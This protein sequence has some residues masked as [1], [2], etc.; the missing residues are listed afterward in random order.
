MIRRQFCLWCVRAGLAGGVAAIPAS[1]T[2]QQS[3]A[4]ARANVRTAPATQ[5]GGQQQQQPRVQ[6]PE[7]NLVQQQLPK[8]L[9]DLLVRWEL[10]SSKVNRLN[11][12]VECIKYDKVYFAE[13][14]AQGEFWYQSPD[15]GRIDFGPTANSN[16]SE[17]RGPNGET[18]T[19]QQDG[20]MRWICDGQ[21]IYIID[22]DKKLA[23]VGQIPAHQQGKNIVNSPLPFIFGLKAEQAKQ[24]Y[25]LAL[26]S[27]HWPDGRVKLKNGQ[28]RKVKPQ[29]HI[30]AAPRYQVDAVEWRRAEVLLDPVEFVPTAIRLFSPQNNLETVYAFRNAKKNGLWLLDNPFNDKPPSHYTITR[31][32]RTTNDETPVERP[33]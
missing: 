20:R 8:E 18:Y 17:K 23:D 26:G 4:P 24:R 11:G 13:T 14:R 7:A 22:D 3:Q 9:E 28:I 32:G 19:V 10:E 29:I 12:A 21:T 33:K 27:M 6:R 31:L 25:H 30:V 2:A 1:A 5:P 16:P 15:K